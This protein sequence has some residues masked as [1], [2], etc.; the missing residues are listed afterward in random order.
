MWLNSL[1]AT[2]PHEGKSFHLKHS[3]KGNKT[4]QC[5]ELNQDNHYLQN[6]KTNIFLKFNYKN[7]SS[8][9]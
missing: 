2:C 4:I 8:Q 6:Y 1:L 5:P 3:L 7:E 9:I